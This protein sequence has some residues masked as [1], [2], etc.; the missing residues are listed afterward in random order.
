MTVW[1]WGEWR[2]GMD[3]TNCPETSMSVSNNIV[4]HPI[5]ESFWYPYKAT[6]KDKYGNKSRIELSVV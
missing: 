4:S 3:F 6:S 5:L 2:K 1:S